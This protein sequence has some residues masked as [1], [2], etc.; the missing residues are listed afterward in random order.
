MPSHE[1]GPSAGADVAR[2]FIYGRKG[3]VWDADEARM[4]RE[5]RR[6]VGVMVGGI[7]KFKQQDGL[8]GVPLELCMEEVTLAIS[9]GW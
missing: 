5:T 3:Y 8:R 7:T 6:I 1:V 9:E 2:V 4:L